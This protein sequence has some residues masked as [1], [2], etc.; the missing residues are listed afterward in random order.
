MRQS[1]FKKNVLFNS[2]RLRFASKKEVIEFEIKDLKIV[3][4]SI[5]EKYFCIACPTFST[6]GRWWKLSI[7][8]T[9]FHRIKVPK[10]LRWRMLW[11]GKRARSCFSHAYARSSQPPESR[12]NGIGIVVRV[13]C[14]A[15]PL[16]QFT[17]E[18]V[19]WIKQQQPH[20]HQRWKIFLVFVHSKPAKLQS[21]AIAFLA[22]HWLGKPIGNF[23]I[24]NK[25]VSICLE[26]G[27]RK[28]PSWFRGL[29]GS[30]TAINA[31]VDLIYIYLC[32]HKQCTDA[33]HSKEWLCRA[34]G[35]GKLLP[36]SSPP[37]GNFSF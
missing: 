16:M 7:C 17:V 22:R 12:E 3:C 5:D 28:R 19:E 9:H 2:R 1:F 10:L 29:R 21:Y 4:N 25:N 15:P 6:T 14:Y 11:D 20:Q 23:W 13:T 35:K 32:I 37:S 27:R 31:F 33:H 18:M 36:F 26:R 24:V 34:P 30:R 8:P